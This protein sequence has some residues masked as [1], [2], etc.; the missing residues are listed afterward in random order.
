MSEIVK[1]MDRRHYMNTGSRSVPV[2]S[3]VGEGFTDFSEVKNVVSVGRR[4]IHESGR[5]TDVTGYSPAIDYE[6]EVRTEDPVITRLRTITDGEYTGEDAKVQILSV[7]LFDKTEIDGVYNAV[8]RTY[9]VIPDRCG[10]GTDILRYS[11]SLKAAGEPVRGTFVLA[12]EVF[13]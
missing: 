12:A 2:W 8:C 4:Y 10:V 5:R 11:G 1:R 9:S 7:D 3:L 6:F 13:A